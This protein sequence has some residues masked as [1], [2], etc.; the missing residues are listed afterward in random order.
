MRDTEIYSGV[1]V[2]K[3]L[4][5]GCQNLSIGGDRQWKGD[6]RRKQYDT[7]VSISMRWKQ[8]LE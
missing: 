3:M 7:Q 1:Q 2:E 6:T 5:A 8:R 4:Q